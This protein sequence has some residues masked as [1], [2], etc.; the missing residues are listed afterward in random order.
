[1]QSEFG[2]ATSLYATFSDIL[3]IA[4]TFVLFGLMCCI[5]LIFIIIEV[6]ET[7]NK[8]LEMIEAEMSK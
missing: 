6:P 8:T 3:G 5:A 1:M 7:R 2:F 4:G